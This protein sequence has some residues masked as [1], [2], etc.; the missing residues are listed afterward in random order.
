MATS[1]RTWIESSTDH[2]TPKAH[3][4]RCARI[5]AAPRRARR[6]TRTRGQTGAASRTQFLTHLNAHRRTDV[7]WGGRGGGR[8]PRRARRETALTRTRAGGEITRGEPIPECDAHARVGKH[9]GMKV[10]Q[11]PTYQ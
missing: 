4:P 9:G 6:T 2:M 10:K 1:N 7:L 5:P 11:S 8:E 3:F